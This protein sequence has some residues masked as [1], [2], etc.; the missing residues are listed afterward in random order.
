MK[1]CAS[2]ATIQCLIDGELSAPESREVESHLAAC[3]ACAQAERA[4]RREAALLSSLLA[5]D[6]LVPVPTGRLWA[7]IVTALGGTRPAVRCEL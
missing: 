6:G 7:G 1:S 3:G 2:E 5:P 4:A